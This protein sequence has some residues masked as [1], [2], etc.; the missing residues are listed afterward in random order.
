MVDHV[1]VDSTCIDGHPDAHAQVL[2]DPIPLAVQHVDVQRVL[3]GPMVVYAPEL[4]TLNCSVY[5]PL[6]IPEIVFKRV[7][8]FWGGMRKRIALGII[9]GIAIIAAFLLFD[10]RM[11]AR[12]ILAWVDSLGFWGPAVFSLI[13]IPATVF[14]LPGVLLTLGAGALFGL[15]WGFVLVNIGATLGATASFL[16]GRYVA[17]DWVREKVKGNEKFVAIDD[18]IGREGWKIVFL[19]RLTPV[20]P[21]NL[22]NYA[23]G[24]TKVKLSHYFFASWIG[25]MP[26]TLLYVYLGTLAGSLATIGTQT[27]TPLEWAFFIFGLVVTAGLVVYVNRVA[28]KALRKRTG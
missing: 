13:Y 10:F 28:R 27:R 8:V 23:Y 15:F 22:Q 7:F 14:L 2:P 3:V 18:A 21:F 5:L 20:L 24:L 11:F 4:R 25:M 12:E 26:G 6:E 16:I 19:T 9:L 1:G 17:R